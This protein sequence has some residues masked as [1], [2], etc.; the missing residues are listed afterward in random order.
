MNQ[1]EIELHD[2][3]GIPDLNADIIITNYEIGDWCGNGIA[4]I[5]I[6]DK[7]YLKS[8]SHCSCYGPWDESFSESGYEPSKDAKADPIDFLPNGTSIYDELLPL[9]KELKTRNLLSKEQSERLQT[10][11]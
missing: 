3:S 1:V 11:L 9:L 5:K 6:K 10:F 8:M 7:W 2:E 4:L